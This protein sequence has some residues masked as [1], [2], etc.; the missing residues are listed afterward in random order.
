MSFT[1]IGYN[2]I[3]RICD[4]AEITYFTFMISPHF[5]HQ[6]FRLLRHIENSQWKSYVIVQ[7]TRCGMH[8]V[9]F[10]KDPLH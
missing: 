8:L 1:D 5:N 9:F 2:S 7:V 6:H 3:I 4:F 10:G